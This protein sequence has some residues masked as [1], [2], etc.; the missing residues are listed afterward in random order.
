MKM[1]VKPSAKRRLIDWSAFKEP[2]YVTFIFFGMLGFIGLYVTVFYISFYGLAKRLTTPEISFYLVP[3]FNAASTFGRI[4]P[5]IIADKTGPLNVLVPAT[6]ITGVLSFCL[7]AAKNSAGLIV[8]AA[9]YGFFSGTFVSLPPSVI[10]SVTKNRAVIGTRMGM[11]FTV[12]GLGSLAGG[13]GAGGILGDVNTDMS[14]LNWTGTWVFSGVTIIAAA[15]GFAL[16]REF[17]TGWKLW[18]KA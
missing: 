15:A 12:L 2:A 6:T 9:F 18:A 11:A 5:N 16:C 13:P 17:K 8:L 14:N 3:I 1:R 7:L 4:I 10:V